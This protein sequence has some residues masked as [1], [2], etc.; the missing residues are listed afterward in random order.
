ML[1]ARFCFSGYPSHVNIQLSAAHGHFPDTAT[2]SC[3]HRMAARRRFLSRQAYPAR[4]SLPTMTPG[5]SFSSR[6]ST[7]GVLEQ[8]KPLTSGCP[9]AG[10]PAAL[11]RNDALLGDVQKSP[12]RATASVKNQQEVSGPSFNTPDP[13]RDHDAF[14][15]RLAKHKHNQGNF[16]PISDSP[17]IQTVPLHPEPSYTAPQ[18]LELARQPRSCIQSQ[19]QMVKQK[20]I[21]SGI[22]AQGFRL[23]SMCSTCGSH[24]G[25]TRDYYM[26]TFGINLPNRGRRKA[27]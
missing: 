24:N 8:L 11:E 17:E 14:I 20:R 19:Q 6:F 23:T 25:D 26:A 18:L 10:D 15:V 22:V 5:A 1:R 13:A 27:D 9:I 4:S 12:S 16:K 2:V 21:A 3:L 7:R